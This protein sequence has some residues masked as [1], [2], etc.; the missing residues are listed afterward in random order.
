LAVGAVTAEVVAV[1]TRRHAAAAGG[2]NGD[3][4]LLAH[5]DN[6]EQQAGRPERVVSLTMRRLL[7]PAAVIAGLPPDTRPLPDLGVYDRQLLGRATGTDHPTPADPEG[8]S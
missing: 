5:D 3:R 6:S 1:E 7:D 4:H 8:T 2:A